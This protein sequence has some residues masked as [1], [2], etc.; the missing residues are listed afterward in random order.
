V[1]I[2]RYGWQ[3]VP[4]FYAAALVITAALFW[5]LSAPDPGAGKSSV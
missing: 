4:R 5:L 2:A 3:S 1:L